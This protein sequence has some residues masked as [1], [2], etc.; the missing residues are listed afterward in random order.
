MA[1]FA[2]GPLAPA[3]QENLGITRAQVGMFSSAIYLG[4]MFFSTHTGWLTDKYGVRLFLLV[5]SGAQGILFSILALSHSFLLSLLIVFL[6]GVGY[7]FINP[8]TVKGLI[9]WFPP[10]LRGTAIGIKQGGASFGGAV[11]SALLPLLIVSIGWQGSIALIGISILIVSLIVTL[12]YKEPPVKIFSNSKSSDILL[13]SG[14]LKILKN[15][16]LILLGISGAMYGI[17][18]TAFCTY[19]ILFLKESFSISLIMAGSLLAIA[20]VGT[21]FGRILW[22]TIS[23]R[24][25]SGRRKVPF[26]AIGFL[27]A[28]MTFI[29]LWVLD[30]SPS[31]WLVCIIFGLF[32]FSLGFNGLL[33]TFSAELGREMAGTAVGFV[34]ATW[35]FGVVIGVPLFGYIADHAGS[36]HLSWVYLAILA[37]IGGVTALFIH[38]EKGI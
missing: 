20:Q 37:L 8:A 5:G 29:T 10:K 7:Q 26:S 36:Y 21:I 16:N 32:G 30:L 22:G 17:S 33:L 27:I 14:I 12:L 3:L 35:A 2:F 34:A 38:E 19:L 9:L 28:M 31:Y 25:F 15:R 24:V 1:V 6:A 11:V 4:M 18:A 23:D 13:L